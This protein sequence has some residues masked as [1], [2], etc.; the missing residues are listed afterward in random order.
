MKKQSNK[1][2]IALL[3]APLLLLASMT[4]TAT[5]LDELLQ[6]DKVRIKTWIEPVEGIVARQQVNL[7][8]EVATDKWF[9][10][11][12]RI[13]HVEIKDAIVLQREQFAVNSTRQDGGKTWTVQQWAIVIYPQRD[14]SFEIPAISLTLSIAGENLEVITGKTETQPMTFSAELPAALQDQQ[15]WVATTDFEVNDSFDK[16]FEE[17]KIGDA[18]IRTISM[19]ASNLPAM[20]LPKVM[21]ADIPGIAIYAKPPRLTDKV[22]R[23]D[24]LAERTQQITY[25]FEN[26]GEFELPEE[27]FHWWNL[28]TQS[29]EMVTLPA[30]TLVIT[31]LPG[32][33]AGQLKE[34]QAGLYEKLKDNLSL[35][36]LA[37]LIVVLLFAAFWLARR[38]FSGFKRDH[39]SATPPSR[40]WLLKQARQACRQNNPEQALN[41]LYQWLG[42]DGNNT[43]SAISERVDVLNNDQIRLSY[44]EMMQTI[45]SSDKSQSTVTCRFIDQLTT[46]I[47]KQH[48]PNYTLQWTVEMKLN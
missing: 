41:Y 39:S 16:S 14:G 10:G 15:D 38:W 13:G 36:F 40:S 11:G 44:D 17:L 34:S 25:V 48:R 23:G 12:T 1:P 47:K 22:N 28:A 5:T 24:Y 42:H 7:Q 31:G 46:A 27:I 29:A 4:V 43:G 26:P 35:I 6:A 18:L 9:S 20:M 37:G 30:Q 45:Y 33:S 32:Q 8:I 2:I 21:T 19:S 3:L